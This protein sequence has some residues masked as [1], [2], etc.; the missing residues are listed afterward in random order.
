M[1]KTDLSCFRKEYRSPECEFSL[2]ETEAMIATSGER[3]DYNYQ[4]FWES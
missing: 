3:D 4:D 1:K 2:I